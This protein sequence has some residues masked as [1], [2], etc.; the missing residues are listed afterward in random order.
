MSESESESLSSRHIH[1]TQHKTTHT[2]HITHIIHNTQTT[3]NTQRTHA[4]THTHTH[5][6]THNTQHTTQHTTHNTHNIQHTTH[7]NIK[8]QSSA[9]NNMT[10]SSTNRYRA[11]SPRLQEH[12]GRVVKRTA[13]TVCAVVGPVGAVTLERARHLVWPRRRECGSV[14]GAFSSVLPTEW[15]ILQSLLHTLR[16]KKCGQSARHR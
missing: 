16:P 6:H 2:A 9:R 5:T 14:E 12:L 7:N 13:G 4:H 8:V 1:T 3:Q 11:R 15:R 10:T